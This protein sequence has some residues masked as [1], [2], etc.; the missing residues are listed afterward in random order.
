MLKKRKGFWK[1]S[2]R[3]FS[4]ADLVIERA[5][6]TRVL[7]DPYSKTGIPVIKFHLSDKAVIKA[8]PKLG[9]CLPLEHHCD[10]VWLKG[11]EFIVTTIWL[12]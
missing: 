7:I 10:W 4:S 8:P 1:E 2:N 6:K 5:I 3:F 12:L 11:L 9:D